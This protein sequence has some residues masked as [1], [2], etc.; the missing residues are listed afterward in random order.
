M[1]VPSVT[2]TASST[3]TARAVGP[4]GHGGAGGVVVHGG[5]QPP[6]A[7]PQAPGNVDAGADGEVRRV[8]QAAGVVD[9]AGRTHAH[10]RHVGVDLLAQLFGDG[11]QHVDE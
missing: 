8:A 9:E 11:G 7:V 1:P 10:G 4:L 5:G 2:I 6:E 3:P